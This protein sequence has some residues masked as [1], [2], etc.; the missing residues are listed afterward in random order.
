MIPHQRNKSRLESHRSG[1]LDPGED[2]EADEIVDEAQ[3]VVHL[4]CNREGHHSEGQARVVD[5]IFYEVPAADHGQGWGSDH[6]VA[7]VV[8]NYA[9][10]VGFV[11]DGAGT[12]FEEAGRP[13]LGGVGG[14]DVC[15][16]DLDIDEDHSS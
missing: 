2:L 15:L 7:G 8:L 14:E 10:A 5:A 12:D 4:G 1:D 6:R 3:D 11:T 16:A 9:G 13:C